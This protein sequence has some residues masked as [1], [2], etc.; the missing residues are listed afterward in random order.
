MKSIDDLYHKADKLR[1]Q[2]DS[3]ML[4]MSKVLDIANCIKVQS[5]KTPAEMWHKLVNFYEGCEIEDQFT[6]EE[7]LHDITFTEHRS[8]HQFL[9][10]MQTIANRLAAMDAPMADSTLVIAI[11]KK[12]PPPYK[13]LIAA[14]RHGAAEQRS[15]PSVI[16]AI[17]AEAK[18]LELANRGRNQHDQIHQPL[19]QVN[20]HHRQDFEQHRPVL[21]STPN[22]A[23]R[24]AN[25]TTVRMV[26]VILTATTASA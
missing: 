15:L 11:L 3:L 12:L 2:Q 26:I 16:K 5:A 18:R 20:R 8:C 19:Q 21:R 9:D 23:I 17:T 7:R 24:S 13:E 10:N 1:Q 25:E 4:Q 14:I 22:I 6:L